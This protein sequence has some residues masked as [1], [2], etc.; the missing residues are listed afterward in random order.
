M[1]SEVINVLETK[2]LRWIRQWS[3][4][5]WPQRRYLETGCNLFGYLQ[6]DEV[7]HTQILDK[8]VIRIRF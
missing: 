7:T 1:H 8:Q 5:Y 3:C 2:N 4:F 6:L